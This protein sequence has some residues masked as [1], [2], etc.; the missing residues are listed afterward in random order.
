VIR[1]EHLF[2]RRDDKRASAPGKPRY[3][4]DATARI[5][6]GQQFCKLGRAE[7]IAEYFRVVGFSRHV[8]RQ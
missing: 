2:K 7:Q 1:S 5:D 4:D 3:Y 6:L 8:Y